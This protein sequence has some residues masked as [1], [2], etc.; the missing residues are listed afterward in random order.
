M[1]EAVTLLQKFESSE[2]S[3]EELTLLEKSIKGVL[4]NVKINK[5]MIERED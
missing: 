2:L 1:S 4:A 3:F 5:L